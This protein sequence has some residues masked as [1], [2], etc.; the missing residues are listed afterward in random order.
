[1]P[2]LSGLFLFDRESEARYRLATFTLKST[3]SEGSVSPTH[4][5]YTTIFKKYI[6]NLSK[7]RRNS[8][9]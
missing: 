4:T 5:Q 9:T 6:T 8:T 1:M 3:Q 2:V 7:A